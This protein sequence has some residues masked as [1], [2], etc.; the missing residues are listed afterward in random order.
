MIENSHYATSFPPDV[1][2]ILVKTEFLSYTL[3]QWKL[4]IACL[5]ASALIACS[6]YLDSYTDVLVS[7]APDPI[8]AQLGPIN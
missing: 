5:H 8:Y 4:S 6:A 1:G 3:L 7:Q 2:V